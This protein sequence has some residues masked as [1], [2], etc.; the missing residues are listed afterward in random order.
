MLR[1]SHRWERCL[2]P[3]AVVVAPFHRNRWRWRPT[4]AAT[5]SLRLSPA[6]RSNLVVTPSP[7]Q[8]C[9]DTSAMTLDLGYGCRCGPCGIQTTTTTE[10]EWWVMGI[11]EGTTGWRRIT[12]STGCGGFRFG[13]ERTEEECVC[14]R[15]FSEGLVQGNGTG[16]SWES[17]RTSNGSIN[18][19]IRCSSCQVKISHWFGA[20]LEA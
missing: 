1:F 15:V 10:R 9:N 7:S 8:A 4:V 13:P 6:V 12:D 16:G 3:E 14:W 18:F 19:V 17:C 5:G 20:C 2:L 11:R